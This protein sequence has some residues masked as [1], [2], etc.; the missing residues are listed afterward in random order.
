MISD[1]FCVPFD[2]ST[3]HIYKTCPVVAICIMYIMVNS[4]IPVIEF[5]ILF[6]LPNDYFCIYVYFMAN[7]SLVYIFTSC[8][9]KGKHQAVMEFPNNVKNYN[10]MTEKYT[11]L[12]TRPINY[13]LCKSF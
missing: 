11:F 1:L 2:V 3:V 5:H 8:S 13:S 7:Q 6:R 10:N 4:N 9:F 12:E